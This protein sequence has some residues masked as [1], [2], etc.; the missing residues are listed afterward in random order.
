MDIFSEI[1]KLHF[2]PDE[3]VIIGGASMVA[4]GLKEPRDIDILISSSLFELC[5]K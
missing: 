4:R 5:Q 1:T 3:Y 2:P